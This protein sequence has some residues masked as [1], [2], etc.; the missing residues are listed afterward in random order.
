MH[1][2]HQQL[3]A[4]SG[5]VSSM[6][7]VR[8]GMTLAAHKSSHQMESLLTRPTLPNIQAQAVQHQAR[9]IS[10]ALSNTCMLIQI[11]ALQ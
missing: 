11:A 5:L 7:N 1:N 10:Q 6:L 2:Q 8:D 9:Y 3:Q 4:Q